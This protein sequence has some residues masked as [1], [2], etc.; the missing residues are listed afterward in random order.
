MSFCCELVW[1]LVLFLTLLMPYKEANIEMSISNKGHAKCVWELLWVK[2]DTKQGVC[3][4]CR[5]QPCRLSASVHLCAGVCEFIL[6]DLHSKCEELPVKVERRL[7]LSMRVQGHCRPLTYLTAQLC[8]K[9]ERDS[10]TSWQ[11]A[12]T[13]ANNRRFI[14]R[15]NCGIHDLRPFNNST[16]LTI[17][18][19]LL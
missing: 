7:G 8:Y 18:L 14:L 12:H 9:Q 15:L 13:H 11:G 2:D 1:R 6:P 4:C 19:L 17:A 3:A 10:Q 5:D 16:D